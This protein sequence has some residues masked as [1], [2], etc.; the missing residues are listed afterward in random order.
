[1]FGFWETITTLIQQYTVADTANLFAII[2]GVATVIAA[3][4]AIMAVVITKKI[5]YEQIEIAK[6]QNTISDK[7]ANIA[8]QQNEIAMFDK[9]FETYRQFSEFL[10]RWRIH[11]KAI[12]GEKENKKRI[13]A[14]MQTIENC[15]TFGSNIESLS[16][17]YFANDDYPT[18]LNLFFSRCK[19]KVYL[20]YSKCHYYF[21]MCN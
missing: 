6:K 5:A 8:V 4:G 19:K 18:E 3:V 13:F 9:K 16:T 7:Q 12:L 21:K 11:I 1:M 17:A 15:S 10:T 14:C 20:C 2:E